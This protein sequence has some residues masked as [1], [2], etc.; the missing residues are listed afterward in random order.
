MESR[1]P[2]VMIVTTGISSVL[3]H[4]LWHVYTV[5][6]DYLNFSSLITYLY[7]FLLILVIYECACW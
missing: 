3:L 6:K 4:G 2:L 7:Q 5:G 1:K